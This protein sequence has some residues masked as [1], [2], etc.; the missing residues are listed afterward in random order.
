MKN[1]N[2]KSRLYIIIGSLAIFVFASF[3]GYNLYNK[4]K[5]TVYLERKESLVQ[6]IET[7]ANVFNET[8]KSEW[9]LA[10]LYCNNTVSYLQDYE[11]INAYIDNLNNL[12]VHEE[13]YFFLVDS[14]GK[15]Y[16]NDYRYGRL[17]DTDYYL[18][19]SDDNIEYLGNLPHLNQDDTYLIFRTRLQKPIISSYN[20][21]QIEIVYCGLMHNIDDID[22]NIS[23]LFESSNNTI[24]FDTETGV[25]MYKH[26]GIKLLIDGYNVYP[27]FYVNE[28]GY[29]DNPDAIVEKIKDY[30]TIV[31]QMKTA[32]EDYY[33]CSTK[34]NVSNWS[35]I[36]VSEASYFDASAGNSYR[37]IITYISLL[38]I[39]LASAVVAVL[40]WY[41]TYKANQLKLI[42]EEKISATLKQAY[43]IKSDFLSN[44][45]HD[46]RTPI[47]GII[48]LATIGAKI[49][50]NSE[51]TNDCFNKINVSSKHLLSLVNDVL[52]MSEIESNKV[53]L[54]PSKFD[55]K[56]MLNECLDITKGQLINRQLELINNLD[57]KHKYVVGDEL[58]LKRVLINVLNNAVKFTK[59][60]GSIE[61]TVKQVKLTDTQVTYEFKIKDTGIGMSKEFLARIFEQFS[62]ENTS[63]RSKYVGT[64]LGMPICKE[65]V[66]MMSGEIKVESELNKG[67]IFTINIPFGLTSD[68]QDFKIK[69]QLNILLVDD[70]ELNIEITKE[71]LK[72]KKHNVVCARN[73]KQAIDIFTDSKENE[74]DLILMDVMMPVMDGLMAT[75]QIRNMDRKDSDIAIIALTASSTKS[76]IE[77]IN[78][79]GMNAYL[80]KPFNIEK[81]YQAFSEVKANE[82]N[83]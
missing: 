58:Y 14:K 63:S 9:N 6:L 56:L 46:I 68:K 29:D 67:S 33:I 7:S 76:D 60:G 81:L 11:D 65:Y 21:E 48:G 40:I 13:D 24:I 83:S 10:N 35:L 45:S 47:N 1:N 71:L 36:M 5:S 54:T 12:L 20:D 23:N 52:D 82:K 80:C 41:M 44:M 15:Y 73:G 79:A 16:S 57:I 75:K 39:L 17:I 59:D 4:I 42:E 70:N 72:E 3:I 61:L 74:F 30:K 19:S 51:Y 8:V 50:G 64:G 43:K 31:T 18:S 38:V 28:L 53:T 37:N 78:E 27:K 55:L 2:I 22:K 66:E 77:K 26:F 34:L 32:N 69:E 49:E 62:Q 25:M